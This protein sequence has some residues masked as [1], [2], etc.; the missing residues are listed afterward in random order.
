MR[1]RMPIDIEVSCVSRAWAILEHV[2][3][4][5]IFWAGS[6]VIRNDIEKQAHAVFLQGRLERLE[7]AFVAQLTVNARG[8]CH[9]VS[10]LTAEPAL[11][12][13]LR[14][15][16]RDSEPGKIVQSVRCAAERKI[17]V[18]LKPVASKRNPRV[19]HKISKRASFRL[20]HSRQ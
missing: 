4:P 2:H 8:I 1:R 12:K 19:H 13:R 3:P 17:P 7:L 16:I 6:H 10:V 9:V 5:R 11:Q 15:D 18:E 20:C 14:V